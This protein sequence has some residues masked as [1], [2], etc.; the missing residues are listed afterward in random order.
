MAR[1]LDLT[2]WARQALAR[3]GIDRAVVEELIPAGQHVSVTARTA[4]GPYRA[5]I[6]PGAV[7]GAATVKDALGMAV[8][9][10]RAVEAIR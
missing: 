1:K 3:E 2:P 5:T 10:L 9:A 6:A 7:F 4:T 8:G